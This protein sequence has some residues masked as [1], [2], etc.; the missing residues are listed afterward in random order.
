VNFDGYAL[1]VFHAVIS[2]YQGKPEGCGETSGLT[3]NIHICMIGRAFNRL[4]KRELKGD[5]FI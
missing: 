4:S 1:K 3:I 5:H 2:V